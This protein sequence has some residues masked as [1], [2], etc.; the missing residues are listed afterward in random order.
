MINNK[1]NF[2]LTQQEPNTLITRV[3]KSHGLNGDPFSVSLDNIT[4]HSKSHTEVMGEL[5]RAIHKKDTA[6]MSEFLKEYLYRSTSET[7][8][9]WR[10]SYDFI[11]WSSKMKQDYSLYDTF[12][13]TQ[14]YPELK[15]TDVAYTKLQQLVDRMDPVA[16]KTHLIVSR[17]NVNPPALTYHPRVIEAM[18]HAAPLVN[19]R[20]F[21][22]TE[23]YKEILETSTRY[24][25]QFLGDNDF[26]FLSQ[27]VDLNERFL[28]ATL[29][30]IL[31]TPLRCRLWGFLFCLSTAAGNFAA[32]IKV[33]AKKVVRVTVLTVKSQLNNACVNF[34]P[35][36]RPKFTGLFGLT[37]MFL[38]KYGISQ[39]AVALERQFYVGFSGMAGD[40]TN[41][42][43]SE[44]SKLIFEVTKTLS[45]FSNAALAGFIE[46]KE[47]VAK[48]L[49]E[50]FKRR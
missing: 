38:Y 2:L 27:F 24:L 18:E 10:D 35:I 47:Q 19:N 21:A 30:P 4:Q 26:L 46:P 29:L 14:A 5:M 49:I 7:R 13:A 11:Q 34:A 16:M 41:L 32:F 12:T 9:K 6:H 22:Q 25:T 50:W 20:T 43:R 8:I 33:V 31:A 1:L 45:T 40:V 15:T 28:M 39:T 44:G 37:S 23:E 3:F 48:Q 17:H 36:L 42:L